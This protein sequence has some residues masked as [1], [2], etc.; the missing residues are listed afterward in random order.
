M[1]CKC[2]I[3]GLLSGVPVRSSVCFTVLFLWMFHFDL[4][5]W[6]KENN[7]GRT[8]I[9]KTEIRACRILISRLSKFVW[10]CSW[11]VNW[12]VKTCYFT[13][14]HVCSTRLL[15]WR[16]LFIH[17]FTAVLRNYSSTCLDQCTTI[18]VQWWGL[19]LQLQ[20]LFF[21]RRDS[22]PNTCNLV[23]NLINP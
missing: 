19:S 9:W 14:L 12:S 1:L 6:D 7:T 5:S 23:Q 15:C 13:Y 3:V 18:H 8:C 22:D 17:F 4:E 16:L 20:W 21:T 11:L 2:L 10:T